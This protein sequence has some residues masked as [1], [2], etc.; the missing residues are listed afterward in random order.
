MSVAAGGVLSGEHGIGLEKRDYMSLMFSEVDL[1]AQD[2]LRRGVR[3]RPAGQPRQGAA[4]PGVVRRHPVRARR[5]LGLIDRGSGRV[6]GGG[7]RRRPGDDRRAVD[8]RRSGRRGACRDGAGRDRLVQPDEMTVQCGAGTPVD[9][10]DDGAG[11]ARAGGGDPADRH[12]RRS[13]RG[14]S[15]R[16]PPARVRADPRRAAPGPVRQRR[17][18]ASSRPAGRRSRTSAGSTC[19]GCSSDR[20]A[21]S[22][23]SAR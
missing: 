23:S 19:A 17:R 5:S 1:A 4:E 14:R 10:L 6:R 16:D 7:R 2:A 22:A 21:R 20:A 9:E 11:R 18:R 13:A 15:Q 12:G 8:P 3:P